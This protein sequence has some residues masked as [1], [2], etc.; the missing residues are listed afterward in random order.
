[1]DKIKKEETKEN[2][3]LC[4]KVNLGINNKKTH[5]YTESRHYIKTRKRNTRLR[6]CIGSLSASNVFVYVSSFPG[7]CLFHHVLLDDG[8]HY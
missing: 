7:S 1:M 8:K 3:K 4:E 6:L 5:Y 2:K